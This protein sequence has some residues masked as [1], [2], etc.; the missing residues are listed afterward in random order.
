M[1]LTESR[2]FKGAMIVVTLALLAI[3][4]PSAVAKTPGQAD[5]QPQPLESPSLNGEEAA[6]G[7][8][9]IIPGHYIVVLEDSVEHPGAL[10][11]KQ[12][13]RYDGELGFV[14]RHALEG[15]SAELSKQDVAALR[16]DPRV[17]Y[18]TPDHKFE[19]LSQTIPTGISRTF[20]TENETAS[21]DGKDDRVNVDVAVIDTGVDYEHPDLNV[22]K[23]ANCV[24]PD[25]SLES[26]VENCVEGTGKDGVG[27]G[28]HVA[29]T[30]GAL[31]NDYGVV[32]M[33]PGARLWAVKVFTGGGFTSEA[34]IVAGIDWVTAHAK[35]IEVANMSL[36]CWCDAPA[37]EAAIDASVEAGVVY[38]VAAGNE[39]TNVSEISP[40]K[41]PNVITVSA[42]ADYDGKAGGKAQA[43]SQLS[44]SCK[45]PVEEQW[46]H[47]GLDDTLAWF[48]NYGE[49][50]DVA[51]PGVCILSS[52][53]V[54][55]KE[56]YG[57][58]V[59]YAY[60]S[61]TS[62][63]AP[64]VTGAA[65]LLASKA[66][67]EDKADVEA[68]RQQIVEA[69][70][71]D[72]NDNSGLS[73][74]DFDDTGTTVP[75]LSEDGS[76][77]PLLDTG[78]ST[79]ASAATG[80]ATEIDRDAGT[81]VLNG[82]VI[83]AGL[84]TKYHFEYGLTPAY[85]TSVPASPGTVGAKAGYTQVSQS[86]SGLKHRTYHFRLVASNS[87][88]TYYGA[89]HAFYLSAW[90]ATDGPLYG[91]NPLDIDCPA[92]GECLGINYENGEAGWWDGEEWDY[93]SLPLPPDG[94]PFNPERVSC[95]SATACMVV[96]WKNSAGYPV[97]ASERWDGAKW[98][99]EEVPMPENHYAGASEDV[100]DVSCVS[101]SFCFLV[102]GYWLEVEKNGNWKP[103]I[104][105]EQWNGSKWSYVSAPT[106]QPEKLPMFL[107]AVFCYSTTRCMAVGEKAQI[108]EGIT[109][110][111]PLTMS[112]DG[113]SWKIIEIPDYGYAEK[114]IDSSLTGVSCPV[115]EGCVAVGE[116]E[117][118]PG[119]AGG[120]G[121]ISTTWNDTGWRALRK[122]SRRFGG[123]SCATASFCESVR[124]NHAMHWDGAGWTI[125]LPQPPKPNWKR[126]LFNVSCPSTG[127]CLATG[128]EIEE[129]LLGEDALFYPLTE[130][131][132]PTWPAA[133]T[134]GATQADGYDSA[135]LSGVVNPEGSETTYRFEYD[136][137]PYEGSKAHGAGI[138]VPGKD[139]GSSSSDIEVSE[140]IEGLLP[141]KTYHYRVVASNDA[142]TTYGEDRT[143]ETKIPNPAWSAAYGTAGS[144]SGQF[145]NPYGI[146]VDHEENVWVADSANH[147]TQKLS[148]TG[149][150]ILMVGKE[151]NKTKSEKGG[152]SEAERNLCTAASGDKCGAGTGP[153]PM[154]VAI[155]PKGDVWVLETGTSATVRHYNP[156]GEYLGQVGSYG[157]GGDGQLYGPRGIA[158]DAQ[159]N[160]WVADAG[161]DRIEQF[162]P[163]GKYLIKFGSEGTGSGQFRS[164]QGVSVD[165][166]GHIWVADTSNNRVQ[167]FDAKGTF[168]GA[169]GGGGS[170]DGLFASPYSLSADAHGTIWVVDAGNHRIE[171][172]NS[173]GEYVTK[174]GKYGTGNG[175]L[176]EPRTVAFDASG[177][178]WVADTFNNRI[179]KWSLEYTAL[180]KAEG[181]SCATANRYAAETTLEAG[182]ASE[183]TLTLTTTN[184]PNTITCKESNLTAKTLAEG[185]KPLGLSFSK[186]S[187][188]QCV[189]TKTGGTSC[190]ASTVSLGAGSSLA[191]AAGADG[192]LSVSGTASPEWFIECKV[193][194]FVKLR[195]TY[196]L[197]SPK[198]TLK[199]GS[200]AKIVV[201][202]LKLKPV[203][204]AG[205][206]ETNTLEAEYS[207]STPKPLY[208]V[209]NAG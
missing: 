13:D 21:I 158:F 115:E 65:A 58:E 85:G 150:F 54:F 205:C 173:Q 198:A 77:P 78:P 64:H 122:A 159:G 102:G 87:S 62:M 124:G 72:W 22:Y 83:P 105:I 49:G 195:C 176:Y 152:T 82:A 113:S 50:V 69:G 132:E 169:Y 148:P 174:F 79:G 45:N 147:R 117:V 92:P 36:G 26:E 104:L 109:F 100:G 34:W 33:A 46:E 96:G 101:A 3:L 51:A 81:A 106:P 11:E 99:Y 91:E 130:I 52:I 19:L 128:T 139:V 5:G 178:I 14:Y 144:G 76:P 116:W 111:A 23:R 168:L 186:W 193:F 140:T 67:P 153:N 179:Q 44:P 10:A 206:G 43:F 166:T 66:N 63:A 137:S 191:W 204:G 16:E 197:G 141:G 182:L 48:S 20:D 161:N 199:G 172:L 127:G 163:T 17:K 192:A 151:V 57:Y 160:L 171:A 175:R 157:K 38:V 149:K 25:E 156:K 120:A 37:T 112:W 24:P 53:P 97:L 47:Y 70:N 84:E 39:T 121:G 114:Y 2:G 125:Q 4:A 185:A 90:E 134:T 184:P 188:D 207:L 209:S 154:S 110:K 86:I 75:D 118:H 129:A 131:L 7:K 28:T 71:L 189:N 107:R 126:S 68:I 202:D 27:H 183:K 59:E 15:Y 136:T 138:P 35:E 200:P 164:P 167:E 80:G 208:V 145:E 203:S 30:I 18:V 170:G 142:G 119:F 181:P 32:G 42:L 6:R 9:T 187:L 180:C 201:N 93:E 40:A 155:D 177:G 31:D 41:N 55:F 165:P 88:G 146:A 162:S 123:L 190:T 135:Q 108:A 133:R 73:A 74:F 103:R 8:E 98:H 143:F 94:R 61:G 196:A 1:S 194:G 12:V 60:V 89:D 56:Q 29:G 95:S